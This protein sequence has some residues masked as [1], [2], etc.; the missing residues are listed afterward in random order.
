[1]LRRFYTVMIVPHEGG[2]LRKMSVSANFVL[3]MAS[4]FLFCFVSSAFL[5]HFF[6]DGMHRVDESE[7]LR[8]ELSRTQI[9]LARTRSE[10]ETSIAKMD[11]LDDKLQQY[12]VTHPETWAGAAAGL[13]EGGL[14]LGAM[15]VDGDLRASARAAKEKAEFWVQQLEEQLCSEDARRR[16][17]PTI[18]P[19]NE[20]RM[21]SG[22]QWRRDP[23][24]GKKEFHDGLDLAAAHGTPVL[25]TADGYVVHAG[26]SG[27][28]GNLVRLDHGDGIE[29]IY[30]HLRRVKVK[31]GDHVT[32]GQVVG[33]VGNT[34]RSTGPHLHYGIFEGGVAVNPLK[35]YLEHDPRRTAS[36]SGRPPVG[37]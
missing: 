21:T 26:R 27:G 22:F 29:T 33:E 6:L 7:R 8:V 9:D 10:L 24:N 15:N 13:G 20:I 14:E 5:A 1:M 35:D 28:F 25:A 16:A 32:K 12:H 31:V 18:W 17:T 11:E 3:C 4:I 19:L 36:V 34:G 30:G 37:G 23:I 2:G